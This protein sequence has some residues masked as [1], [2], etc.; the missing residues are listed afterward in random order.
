MV[1][2]VEV[3]GMDV[4]HIWMCGYLHG[5][6]V[7]LHQ[8]VRVLNVLLVD[9]VVAVRGVHY[10]DDAVLNTLLADGEHDFIK[11]LLVSP[12]L[13]FITDKGRNSVDGFQ[14]SC[15]IP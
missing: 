7:N 8:L 3:S 15:L 4:Q 2:V 13:R 14:A 6:A 9:E 1:E 10:D 11:V 12:F 5:Y